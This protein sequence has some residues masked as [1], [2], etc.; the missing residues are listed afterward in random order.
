LP[1][2]GARARRER[3][4]SA[5]RARQEAV[6]APE[7]VLRPS[8][9]FTERGSLWRNPYLTALGW[10]DLKDKGFLAIFGAR[11]REGKSWKCKEEPAQRLQMHHKHCQ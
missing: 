3:A 4:V 2:F 9:N 1:F 5:R 8:S 10:P 11:A 7:A 6:T